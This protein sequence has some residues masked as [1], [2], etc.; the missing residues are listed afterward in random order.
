MVK[1]FKINLQ[2]FLRNCNYLKE[3]LQF[4]FHTDF[5]VFNIVFNIKLIYNVLVGT[6]DP[7]V[8]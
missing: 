7:C 3:N 4:K 1:C 2:N 6:D 8:F 5:I